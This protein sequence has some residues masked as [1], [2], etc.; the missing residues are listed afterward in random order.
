MPVIAATALMA[1]TVLLSVTVLVPINNRIAHWASDADVDRALAR[2]WDRFHWL[3]VGLLACTF[4]LLAM[5][6]T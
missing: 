4:I 5:S 2:R 6:Q 3:R 1:A